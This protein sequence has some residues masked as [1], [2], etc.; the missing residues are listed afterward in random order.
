MKATNCSSIG[1]VLCL[2]FVQQ[3]RSKEELVAMRIS[4]PEQASK[5][6]NKVFQA[7]THLDK[8]VESWKYNVATSI[9]RI[10]S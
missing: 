2:V 1:L 4:E 5:Q 6:T 9:Y 10:C 8:K 3:C 7:Q